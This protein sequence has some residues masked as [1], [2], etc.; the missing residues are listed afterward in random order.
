MIRQEGGN[1]PQKRRGGRQLQLQLADDAKQPLAAHEQ[2]HQVHVPAQIKACVLDG[3]GFKLRQEHPAGAAIRQGQQG[4]PVPGPVHA[5]LQ[6]GD[7]A[8]GEHHPQGVDLGAR[9]PVQ[10]GA[11]AAGVA[12]S[13]AAD[14]GGGLRGVG[15]EE[16][17][18][19][20]EITQSG[21]GGLVPLGD[22][23]ALFLQRLAH[24]QQPNPR[25]HPQQPGAP[26]VPAQAQDA[27][28]PGEV[29]G[30]AALGAGAA[31]QAGHA[32]LGGDGYAMLGAPAQYLG[33]FLLAAGKGDIF[34][35]P[36]GAGF[37]A[38]I[39][40]EGRGHGFNQWHGHALLPW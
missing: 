12:G 2:V 34:R 23:E 39:G 29:Q 4:F 25:L 20:A 35:L 26:A 38:E 19:G 36:L 30:Q 10:V 11:R 8:I 24:L 37:V 6:G 9:G 22:L 40:G 17:L 31:G 5:P 1:A 21:H 7:A 18:P 32:A 16:G 3:R 27:V 15:G 33:D 13:H 14:A 28:H